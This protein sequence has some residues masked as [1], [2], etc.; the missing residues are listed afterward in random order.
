MGNLQEN[1][2]LKNNISSKLSYHTF[3]KKRFPTA[4][5]RKFWLARSAPSIYDSSPCISVIKGDDSSQTIP[6]KE[7]RLSTD[8]SSICAC[9]F[10]ER[11]VWSMS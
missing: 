3:M 9:C 7:V 1:K 10:P 2:K 6:K 8:T 4:L 11:P 5:A